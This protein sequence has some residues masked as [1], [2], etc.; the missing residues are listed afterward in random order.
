MRNLPNPLSP[1]ERACRAPELA[2]RAEVPAAGEGGHGTLRS[3]HASLILPFVV[4]ERGPSFS[5]GEKDQ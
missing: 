5:R 3:A 4:D 2:A 1:R